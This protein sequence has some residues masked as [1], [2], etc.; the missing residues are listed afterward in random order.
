MTA[1]ARTKRPRPVPG[2]PREYH[3]PRFERRRLENGVELVV[4]PVRKLPL[5]TVAVLND[6]GAV[7]DVAGREGTA[8]LVAKLMT[9]GGTERSDGAELTERFE[10]LGASVDSR[11]D[12]DAAALTTTGA[13]AKGLAV[14]ND[15]GSNGGTDGAGGSDGE[16]D[17]GSDGAGGTDSAS[18]GG[19]AGGSGKGAGGTGTGGAGVGGMGVSAGGAGVGGGPTTGTGGSP[20]TGGAGASPQVC[21]MRAHNIRNARNLAMVKNSSASAARRK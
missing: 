1:P 17:G 8:Q 3:F 11:A 15:E 7:C 12:W 6:A 16:G 10:R 14:S 2:P 4:A 21:S 19:A 18:T 13:C 20:G 5:V 9:E